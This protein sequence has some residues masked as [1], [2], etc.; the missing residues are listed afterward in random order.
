MF[1]RFFIFIATSLAVVFSALWW[2]KCSSSNEEMVE[3]VEV[4]YLS[5]DEFYQKFKVFKGNI[6]E[7]GPEFLVNALHDHA[8]KTSAVK[9]SV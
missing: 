4:D 9:V 8:F 5:S 2:M 3:V 7:K 1:Y 6:H